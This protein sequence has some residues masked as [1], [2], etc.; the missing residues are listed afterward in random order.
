M[1]R[2]SFYLLALALAAATVAAPFAQAS[3]APKVDPLAV[4][5]LTGYGLSPSEVA[6]WTTGACSHQVKAASCYTIL[7]RAS[8]PTPTPRVD[9]LAVGFLTG[10]GLSPS[11]VTSWTTGACS[12][13]VK[14]ASCYTILD[15]AST[16]T[17]APRV[18]PLAVG[19]LIGLGLSPSEV[20][21]WTTGACSHEVKAASCYAM[22]E[23]AASGAAPTQVVRSTGFQWGDAG[24]GA[25][26]AAG[27]ILL[28]G[29]AAA[30]L[31]VSRHGRRRQ[32]ARA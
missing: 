9:P 16:S 32:P 20:A 15:R 13:Q 19:H 23:S 17:P 27:I 14:A 26:F 2:K 8:A 6:S 7:D 29:G 10:L 5:F 30:G 21:S 4:G 31:F 22:L 1:I 11:E 28:V 3:P 12:H 25:G 18:D 24:I